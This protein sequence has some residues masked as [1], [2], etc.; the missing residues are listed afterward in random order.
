MERFVQSK[1]IS[2]HDKLDNSQLID[3]RLI[4]ETTNIEYI[5]KVEKEVYNR[6]HNGIT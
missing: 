1:N 4:D 3:L 6:A 2:L 5:L